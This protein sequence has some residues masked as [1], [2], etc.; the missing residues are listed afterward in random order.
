M[1]ALD[2]RTLLALAGA[3]ATTAWAG[4]AQAAFEPSERLPDPAIE[5]LDPSFARYRIFSATVERIA[6]GF[7]WAEGPVWLGDMRCL[8]FSD[9]V[10]DAIMRWDE[11]TGTTSVFR[12]PSNYAN[13][14]ARD[15]QGRLVTCEHKSR[16]VTRTE[17]DGTITTL[18]SGFD[19][20]PANAPNDVVCRSD[21]AIWFTDPA[22]GPN[23][24]EA[25]AQPERPGQVFRLDPR[26]G[27]ARV[28][29]ADIAGPNGLCFSPDETKLYVIESRAQPNRLIRVYDVVGDGSAL[30]DGRVLFDCGRGTADGFRAD[31]DGNLWCGWG[32]GADLDG[33][34]VISP[35]GR[36]IGRI[37]LP[38]RCANLCFGGADG[39]RLFMA[40][41]KSIYALSVNTRGAV[42]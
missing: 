37:R 21:G 33:V 30:A 16:R 41:T 31:A 22:F 25:M 13:G 14:N 2:R 18:F 28:V 15:R 1:G 42:R 9:V 12:K 27:E 39:N 23:P 35:E 29:V 5:I 24:Y 20:K 3:A 32:M 19:G 26:T 38:E 17:H 40:S 7:R 36:A 6:T 34:L 8:L 10:N 4:P 11:A